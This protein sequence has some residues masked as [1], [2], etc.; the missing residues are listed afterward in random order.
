MHLFNEGVSKLPKPAQH[1]VHGAIKIAT[2]TYTAG[3]K[4]AEGLAHAAGADPA[5]IAQIGKSVAFTDVVLAKAAY[6]AAEHGLH[7]GVA[8]ATGAAM[9]PF[10]SLGFLAFTAARHPKATLKVAKI[11]VS[12]VRSFAHLSQDEVQD[13]HKELAE[14]AA[15]GDADTALACFGVAMD[16]TGGNPEQAIVLARKAYLKATSK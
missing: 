1:V 9:V 7:W 15:H 14:L 5:K 8:A 10:G 2:A 4:A 6:L 12:A 11:A 13:W 16:E 3:R